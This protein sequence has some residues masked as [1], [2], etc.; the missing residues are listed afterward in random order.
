MLEGVW[1]VL[2]FLSDIVE[3]VSSKSGELVAKKEVG[4]KD[5]HDAVDERQ[6]LHS[7]KSVMKTI[8][9]IIMLTFP[10]HLW[11]FRGHKY[12]RRMQ[13][14]RPAENFQVSKAQTPFNFLGQKESTCQNSA[15][16]AAI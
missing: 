6:N 14:I 3:N 2:A 4:E 1:S 8:L 7:K 5:L 16:S 11:V 15:H 12:S 10:G 9:A 13:C